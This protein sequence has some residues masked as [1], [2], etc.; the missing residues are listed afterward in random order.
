MPQNTYLPIGEAVSLAASISC[1][2]ILQAFSRRILFFRHQ[3][4]KGRRYAD[5]RKFA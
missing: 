5:F 3:Y 4:E 1:P 2:Q